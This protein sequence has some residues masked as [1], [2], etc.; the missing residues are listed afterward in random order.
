VSADRIEIAD[1]QQALTLDLDRLADLVDRAATAAGWH[2][3]LSIA[4]VDDARMRE[5]HERHLGDPSPTDVMSFELAP[6]LG[7]LVICT[8]T[9][10]AC[11]GERGVDP[12]VELLLYAVHGTLH[13][14]GHD[15]HDDDDRARMQAAERH[16]LAELGFDRPD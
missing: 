11:A 12:L 5:L 10:L 8:D 3:R 6:E 14:V 9:A 13:L 7:E 2:G 1:L 15:D 4:L 16:I